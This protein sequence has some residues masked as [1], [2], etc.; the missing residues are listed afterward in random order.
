MLINIVPE[1]TA[2]HLSAV[3]FSVVFEDFGPDLAHPP[4]WAST[5]HYLKRDE[6]DLPVAIHALDK[7]AGIT[8]LLEEVTF[9]VPSMVI[10]CQFV[11][12]STENWP[13]KGAA[14]L[15]ALEKIVLDVNESS[16]DIEREREWEK[17][18]ERE[19]ERRRFE[20]SIM[21]APVKRTRHKKQ[22]SL[23]MTLVASIIPLYSLSPSTSRFPSPPP[24]PVAERPP[25]ST[26][27]PRARR[28]KARSE[29]VDTF[30]R[31]ALTE[32]ARRFPSGGYYAWIIQSMLR[33]TAES[34]EQLVKQAGGTP[35]PESAG[36]YYPEEFSITAASLPPTP[37]VSDD[38]DDTFE[39][40][41][42]GSSLHTPSS[43]H[44]VDFRHVSLPRQTGYVPR[45][46]SRVSNF[47]RR[48]PSGCAQAL[49]SETKALLSRLRHLHD[50]E[51]SRQAQLEDDIKHHHRV[52][53]IRSRRRAWLN[54]TLRGGNQTTDL[55]LAMSFRSS[56]LVRLSWS[57]DEYE[58]APDEASYHSER[59]E[60]D[61][62]DRL[63]LRVKRTKR[64]TGATRLFPV[65]E[66][67]DEDE[68]GALDARELQL[69]FDGFDL[70][71]ESGAQC[72]D[73]ADDDA[74]DGSGLRVALEIERPQ[75]RP[76]VRTNSMH[77]HRS[78]A[79]MPAGL[80]IGA[81]PPQQ[82]QPPDK[83]P[84]Q[85]PD[86]DQPPVYTEVDVNVNVTQLEVTGY[87]GFGKFAD[88]EFTLAMDLPFNVR[89]QDRDV[90]AN[91]K[92]LS[93]DPEHGWLPPRMSESSE[94]V[95]CR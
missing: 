33:R 37:D 73:F 20:P 94:M 19:R 28:R 69:Q 52:L 34:L 88:D 40:D 86:H 85:F 7:A 72:E 14:C 47:S 78:R 55:G 68:D 8:S 44:S 66:E 82:C 1:T 32:L 87:G 42:D 71:V 38:E 48:V 93:V 46:H 67:D 21:S 59:Q 65:S 76:R 12:G 9:D 63:E 56:P 54:K 27:S 43:P 60:Y 84:R 6:L 91:R 62:Y 92:G 30:R 13:L 64:S 83:P 26:I 61:E 80:G 90:F 70:D 41:T 24:T 95:Q 35:V 45:R 17:G 49:Y 25:S 79:P 5:L 75:I 18:K 57:G 3:V 16:L 81:A 4:E 36:H 77:Q 15:K 29:L 10:S 31:Y 58:Y 23:L 74:D 50:L 89:V 51:S 39:T 22:R 11:D 2:A 53:E